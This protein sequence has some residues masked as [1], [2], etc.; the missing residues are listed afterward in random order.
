MHGLKYKL[1]LSGKYRTYSFLDVLS[2]LLLNLQ[3]QL[4]NIV[5]AG[6]LP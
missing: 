3:K 1:I 5:F 2:I 6:D 4:N